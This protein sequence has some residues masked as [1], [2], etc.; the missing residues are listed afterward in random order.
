MKKLLPSALLIIPL[1]YGCDSNP[2][3]TPT[4]TIIPVIISQSDSFEDQVSAYI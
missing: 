3:D 4:E 2:P 1:L